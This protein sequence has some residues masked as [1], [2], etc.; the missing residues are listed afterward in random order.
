MNVSVTE[1]GYHSLARLMSGSLASS[2]SPGTLAEITLWVVTVF[3][4][5]LEIIKGS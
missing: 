2:L 3:L 5:C 1:S 4:L